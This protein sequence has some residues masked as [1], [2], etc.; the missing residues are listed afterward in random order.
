MIADRILRE[1]MVVVTTGGPQKADLEKAPG[2][3][4]DTEA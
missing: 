1:A 2:N 4:I 3:Q